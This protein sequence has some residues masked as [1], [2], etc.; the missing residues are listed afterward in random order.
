M[1]PESE[2]L[3]LTKPSVMSLLIEMRFQ[4]QPLGTGTGFVCNTT[5]GPA[6]VTN[7]HI[8]SGRRLD[9]RQPLN[10]RTA[11]IPDN[12]R[13]LHNRA[14][15]LGSWVWKTEPLYREQTPLWIEH[16]RLGDRAD[17]AVLPLTAVDDVEIF[18]YE[19]AD[20]PTLVYRPSDAVSVVG[21]PFGM[22]AGGSLAVWTTGF[23]ASEPQVDYNG[24][25]IFLVDCRTRNGQSG[26]AVI[27]HRNGGWVTMED[28]QPRLLQT[29]ATRFVGIYSGRINE[30][31]DLGMVWKAQAVAEAVNSV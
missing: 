31:S 14:D 1:M 27:V 5:S 21:F 17:I 3:L 2:G 12:V 30:E 9:T 24:L 26:S 15:N 18:P 6:L 10:S 25:P 4:D 11:A 22:Q 13:I 28:G 16:P 19:L 8:V 20:G 29:P 7:W 23:V